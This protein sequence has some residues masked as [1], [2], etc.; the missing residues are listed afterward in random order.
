MAI[1]KTKIK[2]ALKCNLNI[3]VLPALPVTAVIYIWDDSTGK[4]KIQV[5]FEIPYRKER[6]NS[7]IHANIC[8]CR[9]DIDKC[10]YCNIMSLFYD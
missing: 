8:E 10:C 4:N 1:K 7:H 6:K 2:R 5:L 9:R 3:L